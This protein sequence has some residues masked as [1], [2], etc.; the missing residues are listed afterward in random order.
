[1]TRNGKRRRAVFGNSGRFRA[2]KAAKQV[3]HFANEC[4]ME[5]GF[6]TNR[7]GLSKMGFDFLSIG[8]QNLSLNG[9]LKS[10]HKPDAVIS[11]SPEEK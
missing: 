7:D 2:P 8:K 6:R 1:V 11:P 3:E 5:S 4:I 10:G 9:R